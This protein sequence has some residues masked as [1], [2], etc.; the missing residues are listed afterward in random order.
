M[1][2]KPGKVF[3]Y[4][5]EP[6][7]IKSHNF[8]NKWSHEV[9]WQIKKVISPRQQGIWSL[10][11]AR[12]WLTMRDFQKSYKVTHSV[13]ESSV[14]SDNLWNLWCFE[15]RWQIKKF[16]LHYHNDWSHQRWK[17][18]DLGWGASNHKFTWPFKQVVL[19]QIENIKFRLSQYLSSLNLLGWWLTARSS[20]PYIQMNL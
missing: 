20:H 2:I 4:Y 7:S 19:W 13:T 3:G 14:K 9:M 12:W 15:I 18:G 5:N 1:A 6:P 16:Y 11:M 8:R 17:S 10:N